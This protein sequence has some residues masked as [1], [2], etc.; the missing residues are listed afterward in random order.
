VDAEQLTIPLAE[1][2]DAGN[3][4]LEAAL[5]ALART[6]TRDGR[7]EGALLEAHQQAA[8]RLAHLYAQGYVARAMVDY[9]AL[10]EL[11]ALLA[12]VAIGQTL[13][14][15]RT[16]LPWLALRLEGTRAAAE[17]FATHPET[18]RLAG[19]TSGDAIQRRLLEALATRQ[20][21][22]ADG[23]GEEHALLRR[24]FRTFAE[25]RVK[26]LAERLHREDALIPDDLIAEAAALGCFGLSIPAE[27]GGAQERP[28]NL[29][30][31]VVTEELSRGALIV[32]SLITRPEILAKA[33]LKGGT[34]AQQARFLPPMASGEKMVA[35]AVTEPDYGSDV[36]NIQTAARPVEGGWRIDGT[37]VWS[38]FA[39][40]AELIGLLA[41]TE[42]DR[43]L[44]HRG[45][46]MFVVEKPAFPGHAFEHAPPR[47]GRMTG[48]AIATLGYRGMHSFELTFEDYFLPGENLV[49]EE[50]GR[51]HGFYLQMESFAYGRM[52]T[53]GRALGV[54]QAAWEAARS[55]AAARRVFGK[56]LADFPL[57]RAKLA[58]M[59][60]TVQAGRQACYA[61]A[62]L[63][64]GGAGQM[65]ASLVKL[66]TCHKA[67]WVT[68]EA[69]QLHG[70]MGYAEEFAVS[71]LFADARVLS[72]FEGAEEV[73][74]LRVIVPALLKSRGEGG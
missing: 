70:G 46:G 19:E 47:G 74:A 18:V 67:E 42:P 31:V 39:G 16:G 60:A 62:R 44:G 32:G 72:I 36:A 12:A 45:L 49:G 14:A 34:P 5:S 37:K 11:Q 33:L 59:A 8:F 58:D 63:L 10:G 24:T 65:E 7:V 3:E 2:L 1:R 6:V 50:A 4:A 71:R 27:H 55:Y 13:E 68:R 64:D 48:R 26:P 38:T 23:L 21:D 35:I 61:A 29:G 41:R 40:R 57:S 30:M 73:L 69:M 43:S 53:A 52:Q 51:G 56:P 9:A 28:D 20:G 15:L 17:G 25:R 22:G 66:F 54:M